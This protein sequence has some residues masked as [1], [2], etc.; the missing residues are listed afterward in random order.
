MNYDEYTNG[1][2]EIMNK[3]GFTLSMTKNNFR[4]LK[5]VV[6]ADG[7][8]EERSFSTMLT[9]QISPPIH[10]GEFFH[11]TR[12]ADEILNSQ[13]LRLTSIKKRLGEDELRD[14]LRDF[15]FEYPLEIDPQTNEP[16]FQKHNRV[17]FI[18]HFFHRCVTRGL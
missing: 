3:H 8:S 14:F 2:N 18:L 4:F 7:F 6:V 17:G 1:V 12:A 5:D 10:S 15:G 13:T 11:Y 16:R 9:R